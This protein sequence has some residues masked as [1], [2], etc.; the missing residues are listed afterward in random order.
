MILLRLK[1][2]WERQ[3]DAM[4]TMYR[5]VRVRWV[6]DLDASGRFLDFVPLSGDQ[7]RGTD[8][9]RETLVPDLVVTSKPVPKLLVGNAEYVLGVGEHPRTAER[10]GLFRDLVHR[11]AEATREPAVRAVA[12]FLEEHDVS[13]KRLPPDAKGSDVY[14]FRVDG[15]FPV[16]LD[17]VRRFWADYTARPGRPVMQCLICGRVGPVED[18]LPAK[19]K[20]VPGGQMSGTSVISA[21]AKA[22]ESYGLEASLIAPTCRDCGE[23]FTNA[24]GLMIDAEQHHVRVGPSIFLFWTRQPGGF[25]PVSFLSQPSPEDVAEL[26]ASYRTGEQPPPVEGDDFY[27][28]VLTAS[29]GRAVVRDWL[30][31]T[32]VTA[33]AHLARWFR[34]QRI[35]GEWGEPPLPLGVF[36]LSASLYL[37]SDQMVPN[38][39]RSL[40]Q[41]A[42]RG[43]P[44][45]DS[46]LAQAVDRNRA[47]QEVTRPRAALVKTVLLSQSDSGKEETYMQELDLS[48][49]LPAYLCGRLLAELEAAQRAAIPGAKATIVD[50]FYGAASAAPATVF[51]QL[52]RNAQPHLAKLRKE[53]EPAFY[54]ID[55]RLQDILQD[56]G[57]FPK[58][59]NLK[60]QALFAL[61]YYHQ[62]AANRAAA[63]KAKKGREHED[64]EED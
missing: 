60:E 19:V 35:V 42:L 7:R 32:V 4:P 26:L 31:T 9:G 39:A 10:H 59:L 33:K 24:I 44:L 52:L 5:R 56:L 37:R 17:S 30:E 34:L 48:C 6:I 16:D 25:S 45:P 41:C 50:R 46:L 28:T 58:T 57:E 38:V 8:R 54:A 62:R 3:P 61:G 15:R 11:C 47:E 23:K 13:K 53:R 12:N 51:G 27:A 64:S 20:G 49:K 21:N 2:F 43:G 18:R 63:L 14:T 1:E 36:A 22:F 40:V 29:G 55:G